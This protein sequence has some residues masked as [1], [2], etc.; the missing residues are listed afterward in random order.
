MKDTVFY[1]KKTLNVR[2]RL[3]D[4]STPMVMGIVNTTPDSFYENSRVTGPEAARQ[5]V[6]S[7]LQDGAGMI[8]I[9]G[10]SSRPGAAHISEAEEEKRVI[11]AIHHILESFPECIISVDTFRSGIARKALQAGACLINDISGGSLDE[12]MTDI[13]AEH[14]V[15]YILM[16][17]KGTPQTMTSLNIYED[18]MQEMLDY[19]I[20]KVT[21]LHGKGIKDIIIDPGFG[22]AKNMEQNYFL[23]KN[24]EFLQILNLPVLAGLSGKSMIYKKLNVPIGETLNGSTVL[25]TIAVSKGASILRVHHVKEAVETVKLLGYLNYF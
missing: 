19:F 18:L 21:L 25:Q 20:E 9:G 12:H 15:P 14:Q 6:A 7:M 10:Y 1:S 2:G 23:L 3:L 4:L 5:M 16:H 11:P 13:A 8:D 17:M 22:F 24:M